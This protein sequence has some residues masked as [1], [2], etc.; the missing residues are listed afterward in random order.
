MSKKVLELLEQRF[1]GAI[2]ET[3]SSYG[4]DTAV[5]DP[6]RWREIAL[7][8]RDD[9][10]CAFDMFTDLTAV[11]YMGQDPR[12]EVVCHLRS[13]DR[14]HRIRIKTRVGDADGEG[15]ELDSLV[16]VWRGANWYERETFD[17]F[18]VIFKGHPDLRRILMYPEFVGHPLRKDYPAEKTQPLVEYRKGPFEKLPPFG[19]EEGLP[20]GRQTHARPHV[21]HLAAREEQILLAGAPGRQ[22]IEAEAATRA[23]PGG[24][25]GPHEES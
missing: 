19:P 8:L 20:F 24:A 21:A 25:R 4:D 18:G 6:A 14:V 17:M 3:H 5:V 15:A 9:P 13:L 23:L 22:V 16:P 2:L 12:F 11:D 1:G 10:R 7:F